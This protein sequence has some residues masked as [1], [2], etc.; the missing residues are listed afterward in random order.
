MYIVW[1]FI[2]GYQNLILDYVI[3]GILGF[4]MTGYLPIGFEFAS[5][6]SYPESETTSSG[7]LNLAAMLVGAIITPII[8]YIISTK[9]SFQANLGNGFIFQ[10]KFRVILFISNFRR[11]IIF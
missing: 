5:E 1:T 3:V 10:K 6:I 8:E 7:F 4:F 11:I 2:L 9:G